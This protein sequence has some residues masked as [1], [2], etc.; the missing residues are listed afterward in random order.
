MAFGRCAG[1]VRFD[2]G[3]PQSQARQ[4]HR[5]A[6]GAKGTAAKSAAHKSPPDWPGEHLHVSE[7]GTAYGGVSG[8]PVPGL[9]RTPTFT[10]SAPQLWYRVRGGGEVFVEVDSHRMIAGPLHGVLKRHLNFNP[11]WSWQVT[12]MHDYIGQRAHIEFTPDPE[13]RYFAVSLVLQAESAPPEPS[14]ANRLLLAALTV[15][16]PTSIGELAKRYAQIFRETADLLAAGRM[17]DRADAADR[18]SL[19]NWLLQHGAALAPDSAASA[20]AAAVAS[21]ESR[22]RAALVAQFKPSATAMA[23]LDGTGVDE[24]VLI[25]GNHHTPGPLVPRRFLEAI[26]GPNQPPIPYGSGRLELARRMTDSSDPFLPR[27]I[28]NRVWQHLFGRGI[29]ATV[30]N[31]GVMGQPP[32]HP[33]LLDSLSDGFIRD[34][35]SIKRLIRRIVLSSTY[36][37]SSQ[38]SPLSVRLDPQ[39]LLRQHASIRRLEGEVIRDDILAV[40]G[41]LNPQ[42]YGPSE[43]IYLTSFMEGRGRPASGPLDGDGRRSVYLCVRRNFLVPMFSAF[44][45]PAPFTTVGR[46]TVSNLPAQALILLND[47][48]VVD[49]ARVWAQRVL[50]QKGL[51]PAERITGMYA[52]AFTR[53]PSARE[54]SAALDFLNQQGEALGLAPSARLT[55]DARG[56]ISATCC[57]M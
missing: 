19:A 7:Q 12:D 25:R 28:V 33:E 38:A 6:A 31:F 18:A 24:H 52:R 39:N 41:R 54:L 21:D 23:M 30:D 9:L 48:F 56:P 40:S 50:A 20:K 53:P 37:M 47:P 51:T 3:R 46:R 42:V 57:S 10:V 5:H 29:V 4:S 15:D 36:R 2:S 45:A 55:D 43:P 11:S 8:A 26:S 14:R 22:A 13:P 16:P 44:D 17:A 1:E 32:T 34:G 27:V 49:Q 35:W